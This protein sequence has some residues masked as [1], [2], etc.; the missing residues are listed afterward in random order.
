MQETISHIRYLTTSVAGTELN[1][2][3]DD[4]RKQV[5]GFERLVTATVAAD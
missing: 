2:V 5:K 4:L 3:R 1:G